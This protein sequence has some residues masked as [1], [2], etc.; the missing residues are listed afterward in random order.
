MTPEQSKFIRTIGQ[1]FLNLILE[2]DP[3]LRNAEV[4]Q[5]LTKN[6]QQSG[7]SEV[8]TIE[9]EPELVILKTSWTLK[10]VD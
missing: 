8:E 10:V 1:T 9:T 4:R 6:G 7:P 5:T 2:S 3:D